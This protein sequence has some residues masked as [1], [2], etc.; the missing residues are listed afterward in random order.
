M[1]L[2]FDLL[3]TPMAAPETGRLR[4]KRIAWQV[5]CLLTALCVGFVTP[6]RGVFGQ[7][8]PC[9]VVVLIMLTLIQS[10]IYWAAKQRADNAV[11]MSREQSE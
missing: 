5:L 1:P 2:W 9:I 3:R 6:L 10:L 11:L 8:A 7:A 4:R